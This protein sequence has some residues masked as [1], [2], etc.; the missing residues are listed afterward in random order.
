MKMKVE[1]EG[2]YF[3]DREI[4]NDLLEFNKYKLALE[5]FSIQLRKIYKYSDNEEE[6]EWASKARDLL[7]QILDSEGVE[8]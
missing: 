2:D 5:E 8:I 6:V 7:Y 4:F 1:F 3:E